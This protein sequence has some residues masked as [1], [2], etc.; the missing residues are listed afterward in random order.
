MYWLSLKGDPTY[1]DLTA[2][3]EGTNH[4]DGASAWDDRLIVGVGGPRS[5]SKPGSPVSPTS[6]REALGMLPM[7]MA[8]PEPELLGSPEAPDA[9]AGGPRAPAQAAVPLGPRRGVAGQPSTSPPRLKGSGSAGSLSPSPGL[10]SGAWGGDSASPPARGA[11]VAVQQQRS[12]QSRGQ[13]QGQAPQYP[14]DWQEHDLGHFASL[15]KSQVCRLEAFKEAKAKSAAG[16]RP[17][18]PRSL[19]PGVRSARPRSPQ[20][21]VKGGVW[22][23]LT[24]TR[25]H[26]QSKEYL[27]R[28]DPQPFYNWDEAWN[29]TQSTARGTSPWSRD[30]SSRTS[31]HQWAQGV[32]M[33][34]DGLVTGRADGSVTGRAAP[35]S[36]TLGTLGPQTSPPRASQA[37][38][39]SSRGASRSASPDGPGRGRAGPDVA[40]RASPESPVRASPQ[41][42]WPARAASRSVSPAGTQ[43]GGRKAPSLQLSGKVGGPLPGPDQVLREWRAYKTQLQ[44]PSPDFHLAHPKWQGKV[45]ASFGT[46]ERAIATKSSA[47][48]A[49]LYRKPSRSP[50]PGSGG[51]RR[52][53]AFGS[54]SGRS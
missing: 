39:R 44:Q 4:W 23:Q 52:S 50:Q 7:P 26:D 16:G 31:V 53:P 14:A 33:Q 41:R 28:N 20:P 17:E 43:N 25:G 40:A 46:A 30:A 19:S 22:S 36:G 3:P 8:P 18:Y 37:R 1:G 38:A 35:E 49:E 42:A 11:G 32:Q 34:Q 45:C 9:A 2:R 21:E 47:F 29:R 5:E 13:D 24:A 12:S 51:R 15:T 54:S 48:S 27:R 10:R 6:A